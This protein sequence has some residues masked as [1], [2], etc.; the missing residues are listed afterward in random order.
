M[1]GI[2]YNAKPL[3]F[4]E[5]HCRP[6][7]AINNRQLPDGADRQSQRIEVQNE[8]PELRRVR[9]LPLVVLFASPSVAGGAVSLF[10]PGGGCP[11][12]LEWAWED[13]PVVIAAPPGMFDEA[14]LFQPPGCAERTFAGT[15][16]DLQE[17]S[18]QATRVVTGF[19]AG[20]ALQSSSAVYTLTFQDEDGM[21]S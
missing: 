15:S 6:A 16:F 1:R 14:E 11:V 5:G 20:A 8:Y 17:L 10:M 19:F 12:C 4:L 13:D 3:A 2:Q 21:G 9:S 7:V 18:L